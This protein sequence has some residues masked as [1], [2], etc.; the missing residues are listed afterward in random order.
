MVEFLNH[1]VGVTG[2]EIWVSFIN[3]EI[4]EQSKQWMH[5]HSPNKKKMFKQTLSAHKASFLGQD[6]SADSGIHATR[7]HN[8]VE[9]YCET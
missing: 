9:V 5:I 8:N 2:N 3:T 7:D 4:K 1:I 6:R